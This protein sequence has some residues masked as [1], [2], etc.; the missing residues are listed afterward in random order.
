MTNQVIVS[1]QSETQILV[2][3]GDS[4]RMEMFPTSDVF[5]DVDVETLP[6]DEVLRAAQDYLDRVGQEINVASVNLMTGGYVV[7]RPTTS[8]GVTNIMIMPKPEFG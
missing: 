3:R 7:S 1:P 5:A 2:G 4:A 6:D 8:T